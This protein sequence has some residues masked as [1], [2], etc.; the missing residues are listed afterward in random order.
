MWR[1]C[2]RRARNAAP[3]AGFA[4][5]RA[6]LR[7]EPA[8]PRVTSRAGA[9]PARCSSGTAGSGGVRALCSGSLSSW[10]TQRNRLLLQLL[11]SSGRRCYSL[12]PH[13]KVPL[14]SLS[15]TMQAGTIARW[16]KKEGEKINEGELIAEVETDKATVG[17]ESLE[18]CYM[19]KILVAEGTR[20]V[21]VG[22]I[23]CITVEKPEDI[24][25]FKNYTLDSSAAPTPQAAAAPT[26]VA[27]TL[28]PTPPAQAPGSSYPTH[29][30]VV[31]PALS[32]TMTMGTVQRWEKKVGEKLSEGDLL[33]EIET[34]KAT[35]G[36]EVQEE[37][38]LAK[39]L[40]PEGTRDVPLGTPLCIIVEKEEDIP[41]FAD[42]RPTEVTD[43]KP[44]APPSTPPPVAPVP[45]TPQPVTPTPSAPRPATPAG[46]K[47]RLFAS[48][49]AKKL[50]AEKG[51]D[52]TQVK[53]TGP[54]GRIIK[55]DVDSF[56]PTKA[57]PAP[58][59][60][61]PAAVPG[62]APVPSGVFTD[63][64]ISNIRRVI[65]QRL[66]QSKQTIPHYYLSIDVN[67]GE[68]LLVRKELNKML[69]GRSKISVNDF[70]IKA[71][72]LACLKVPEANSSWLDT[73]IR[74]NHVVDVSVAVST[75]AGLITP[76]VFN[77]HIKGLEA[78][79]NDVVSL[80][81][82]AREGKLQ[83]HEFQG[84]TFTISNL[85]MFGIKNFS[86]I[87]NP[88]QACILA[89]GASED[90]LV[91]A[92]NEKGFDVASMMSVTLSCDHRVVD[93][94]VGAQWLAEFRK[95]LE[96]PITML[97]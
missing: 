3:R 77:A 97:L 5:R 38:Y 28:P 65:A 12:P 80:A 9:A 94:A 10:A 71:S 74:Q 89:I 58:A 35:I 93:G 36:F 51:I 27:P 47:G 69:E 64:P 82:K 34:D 15:P 46:P 42:Y 43:L 63:V 33:A 31:L 29:M 87:I 84:G 55:K 96:K 21:P 20:D 14:P 86:A 92:D 2:A 40:I 30:Q 6:A 24:E 73:V 7:E 16:E 25:A 88:P 45:P 76:I 78:I 95:Y 57:A 53:G 4:V 22:A 8:A 85:G 39:I 56:V 62:V 81:T 60:A 19:A 70:I 49:L 75:P 17:F 59:A 26:P 66:M 61:V 48:P 44:Q 11:G 1:V 32:P 68:V 79:A 41:A 50:A 72:A 18:E 67:M 90:R 54:E 37:G 83:P 91:P 13:Q 52:L 23:I